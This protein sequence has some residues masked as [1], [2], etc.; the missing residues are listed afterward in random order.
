VADDYRALNEWMRQTLRPKGRALVVGS[1]VYHTKPD[2]RALYEE[3]FGVDMEDGPG[4]DLVHDLER[5]LPRKLGPFRHLD[6]VSVL[7]HVRNPFK[8]CANVEKALDPG[9]SVL[10]SVP[11]VWR[12][13]GYPNDY[14]RFTPSAIRVL[15]PSVEWVAE[16]FLISGRIMDAVPKEQIGPHRYLAKSELVM[17]G[18]VCG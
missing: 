3:A 6:C 10:I 18:R 11:W 16:A 17:A 12:F 1:K 9:A 7:E 13:H 14:W 8:F 4:V 2:R 5:A 15:F